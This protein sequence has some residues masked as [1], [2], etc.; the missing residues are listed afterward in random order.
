MTRIEAD[1]LTG[2]GAALGGAADEMLKAAVSAAR[3]PLQA[4]IKEVFG[5]EGGGVIGQTA[6]GRNIYQAAPPG[7][8]PGVRTG[9][10]RRSI[11]MT[12]VDANYSARVGTNKEYGEW[13]EYGT[14]RMAARPWAHKSLRQAR[15]GMERA[16]TRAAEHVWERRA[17]ELVRRAG[18]L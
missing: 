18:G 12:E 11:Q 17:A 13:L 1:K 4:T 9:D 6:S 10:L 14:A 7:A 3:L 15:S 8:A 16:A 2:L 5:S